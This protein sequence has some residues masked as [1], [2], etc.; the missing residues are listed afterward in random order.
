MR[1]LSK[2]SLLSLS[3][4]FIFSTNVAAKKDVNTPDQAKY[5]PKE[6]TSKQI[7]EFS[8]N[9][10]MTINEREFMVGPKFDKQA[11]KRYLTLQK[12]GKAPEK[13][14][15]KHEKIKADK[16]VCLY[17]YS[18]KGASK[19]KEDAG[20][21]VDRTGRIRMHAMVSEQKLAKEIPVKK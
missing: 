15:L 20:K 21:E 4:V 8:L 18:Y 13:I 17:T 7:E 16:A 3:A 1:T 12:D 2:I 9:K 10:K 11:G 5:C 19:K 6:L 14:S